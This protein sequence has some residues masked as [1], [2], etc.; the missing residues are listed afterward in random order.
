MRQQLFDIAAEA[1]RDASAFGFPY[2]LTVCVDD[3]VDAA[4]AAIDA[5]LAEYYGVPGEV[6]R[7]LQTTY[8][9]PLDGALEFIRSF[10]ARGVDHVV[11]RLVGDHDR[12]LQAFSEVRADM[13]G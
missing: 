12:Q 11:L 4:N 10:T 8:G 13:M 6:M 5:Y 2:Y 7:S 9:G 3:D 1:G